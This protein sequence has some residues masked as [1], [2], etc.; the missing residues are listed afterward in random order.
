[1]DSQGPPQ[2]RS[3]IV[4]CAV[5]GMARKQ[6][7]RVEGERAWAEMQAVRRERRFTAAQAWM[8]GGRGLEE[9]DLVEAPW[10]SLGRPPEFGAWSADE[11]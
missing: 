4:R 8:H 7:A 10:A 3:A 1:M 11:V 2:Q 6:A 9:E 5:S